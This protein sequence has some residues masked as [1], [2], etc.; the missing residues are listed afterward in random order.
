[1]SIHIFKILF[2]LF[3]IICIFIYLIVL[4]IAFAVLNMEYRGVYEIRIDDE[5]VLNKYISL[6]HEYM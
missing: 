1:M 6:S 3:V 4:P 5:I 2:I